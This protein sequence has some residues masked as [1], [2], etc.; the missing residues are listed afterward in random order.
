MLHSPIRK[1]DAQLPK[2]LSALCDQLDML[3]VVNASVLQWEAVQE[4]GNQ[5]LFPLSPNLLQGR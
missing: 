4:T 2:A 3:A 1:W 5:C